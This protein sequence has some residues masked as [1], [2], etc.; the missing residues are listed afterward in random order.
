MNKLLKR[1]KIDSTYTN[2]PRVKFDSV[3]QNTFPMGGFNYMADLLHLP[4][5]RKKYLYL[6]SMVDIWSNNCD[7]E[8]IKDKKPSTV[9][10]AMKKIFKRG[11][12]PQPQSS[13]RTDGGTEF[14]DVFH[15]WLYD[16]NIF[17]RL[18]EP[19]RHQ[20]MSNVERLNFELGKIFNGYMNKK[21]I[22]TGQEYREWSDI[23]DFV[24][25]E[26][27]KERNIMPDKD[28]F[29]YKFPDVQTNSKYKVGDIVY[30]RSDVPLS[31]LGYK[32]PTKKFRVGDYHFNI[33][34]PRKIKQILYYPKNVRYLLDGKMNVSYAESELKP[35]SD[36][37]YIVKKILDKKKEKNKI[38]YLIWWKNYNKCDSTWEPRSNLIKHGLK[39]LV[40]DFEYNNKKLK[41]NE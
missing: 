28:L 2:K 32:Q 30:Y 21:E 7:F 23:L 27:N 11:I 40:N 29:N 12:L 1:L 9:L 10:I 16:H 33:Y 14:K 19:Y 22:E 41:L 6:L 4:K 15:K 17:H 37:K 39:D 5:T 8:P 36:A 34:N 18:G 31:A 20:Q 35:A 24:R 25:T 26:L 3:K 13:I 38:Y